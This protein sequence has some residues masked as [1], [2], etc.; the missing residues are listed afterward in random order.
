[1]EDRLLLTYSLL[2]H[3]KETY[4]S[5][6]GSLTEIFNPIVKKGLTEYSK[7][8]DLLEIKGA[9]LTE[10]QSKVFDIFGLLIPIPILNLI[11]H[12]IEKEIND[13]DTFKFFSNDGAFII[14]SYIFN[15]LEDLIKEEESNLSILENDYKR[16]CDINNLNCDFQELIDFVLAQKVDL[17]S[18]KKSSYLNIDYKIPK[19]IELKFK[20]DKNFRTISDIYLGGILSS[21]LTLN[22]KEKI[23]S[24]E[25]L[26]DTNFFISL[27]DLNTE[28]SYNVCNQ[29]FDIC[30]RMGFRFTILFT[31]VD[32]IKSLL[33]NRVIDF[34]NKEFIGSIKTAD[35]FNACIRKNLDK[36]QLERIKDNIFRI[37]NDKNIVIINEQQI[38]DIVIKA[39]KSITYKELL[40][41]RHTEES[42]LNDAIAIEYVKHKRGHNIKEFSEVECWLLHNS[43]NKYEFNHALDLHSRLTIG[44]NELL[45]LLWL[46]N[47]SQ[48]NINTSI[49]SKGALN[50]YITKYRRAKIPSK[51]AL[52]IIKSRAD[53]A[54]EVGDISE[55]DLFRVTVRMSEG[56]LRAD[57]IDHINN[58]S[59][60]EFAEHFKQFTKEDEDQLLSISD[61][62]I[63]KDHKIN[64]LEEKI[65]SLKNENI[66]KQNSQLEETNKLKKKIYEIELINYNE[67]KNIFINDAKKKLLIKSRIF[68]FIYV[69]TILG[70][71]IY[72]L[73]SMNNKDTIPQWIALIVSILAIV[74]PFIPKIVKDEYV[75]NQFKFI[76]SSRFRNNVLNEEEN[77]YESENPKPNLSI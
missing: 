13:P 26:I 14:K 2:A 43:F 52:K 50:T 56:Q 24:T 55:R 42:A 17:F 47:P 21:Y 67:K 54:K 4:S 71:I 76:F 37:I 75:A 44:S 58:L 31:T 22:I 68:C 11:M 72:Y 32:E 46:S 15:E 41:I 16:Y 60:N 3:L 74:F 49:L 33:N 10:I 39:K 34:K 48:V 40:D 35:I 27:I 23:T 8:H 9:N 59:D 18:E 69:I 12:E 1:M 28:D 77:R 29:L 36:T 62:L 70:I 38:K 30:N 25:L 53:K 73:L 5:T 20:D 64:T 66:L 19:Y 57:E 65:I 63:Q 61:K 7:E 51:E 45:V 6:T